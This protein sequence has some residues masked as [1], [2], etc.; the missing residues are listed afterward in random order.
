MDHAA[1]AEGVIGGI[2]VRAFGSAR[3]PSVTDDHRHIAVIFD[4]KCR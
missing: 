4:V 3:S 2:A 1:R